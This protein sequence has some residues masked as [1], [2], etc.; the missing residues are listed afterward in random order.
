MNSEPAS[1]LHLDLQPGE[2]WWGGAVADGQAMPFGDR[3][4]RR[5]LATNAGLA[6]RPGRRREPVRTAAGVQPGSLRLVGRPVRPSPSTRGGLDIVGTGVVVGGG[7]DSLAGAFR[8]AS[9]AALPGPGATPAEAMFTGPQY[10]TWIEMPYR[11]DP[12]RRAAYVRGLLDAG[13][14]PGRGHDR[15]P[16][17]AGLRHLAVRAGPRSRTRRR[18]WP[19][20]TSW[21]CPVM[22]WLVPFVSP[23]SDTFRAWPTAGC[24]S[25]GP[26]GEPVG[27]RWWN[28]YSAM[29]DV[30]DPARRGLAARR[31]G[32]TGARRSASTGS[33]STPVTCATTGST[34]SPRRST[35]RDRPVRGVGPV[36]PATT[37]STSSGPAGRWAASRSPSGCTTSRR[38]WGADGLASLIPESIA[39]GLIGLPFNCPDMVGGGDLAAFARARVVDQELFVRYAQ[40]AA[41]FPMMQFS[42]VTEPG[43]GRRAPG[44]GPGGGRAASVAVARA[45]RP[46]PARGRHRR[47]GAAAARLPLRRVRRGPGPVPARRDILVAPVLER[48]ATSR[49]VRLPPGR[50]ITPDGVTVTG[51]SE[52][53][54]PVTL[55]SLPWW[56]RVG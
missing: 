56:R 12:G 24:W 19:S 47:A 7:A 43:A 10:N 40:C 26:D 35:R 3:S 22:L 42:H 11:P 16:V 34:T 21:G 39:Q 25:A 49:A 45:P 8:A 48:G 52:I 1:A 2:R 36:R 18:W 41:L 44:R 14:P 4:H 53:E 20:C 50:W 9:A 15:R 29:L 28:G 32:R 17:V 27:P 46:G 55:A 30:T 23:D 31:A 6:R 54:V 51:P 38:R 13:F 33:S 5:D 37:R